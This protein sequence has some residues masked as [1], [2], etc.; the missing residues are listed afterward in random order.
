MTRFQNPPEGISQHALA[1]LVA[2]AVQ[3]ALMQHGLLLDI[4][5]LVAAGAIAGGVAAALPFLPQA[6]QLTI[7]SFKGGWT[8]LVSE[9]LQT[10]AER[11]GGAADTHCAN[12]TPPPAPGQPGFPQ[13]PVRVSD[14]QAM[15]IE[16]WAGEVAGSTFL[17][18]KF[19]IP[20]STLHRWQRRGE[21]VAL[22][23][24]ASKHVFPLAQFVDGRPAPGIGEVLAAITN[25]RLAWFWLTRPS[26]ELD[27]RIPIDLLR[28]DMI[29]DVVRVSRSV[30]QT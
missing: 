6:E 30:S 7:T 21:V 5:V 11:S 12:E 4:E 13:I 22:R 1:R 25:P 26:P 29:E 23:K 3:Q 18:E 15:L 14:F 2:K 28:D 27:G 8:A 24:G 16:D 20:R 9:F 17:E 10:I 19:G